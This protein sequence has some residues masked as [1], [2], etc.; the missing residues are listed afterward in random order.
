ME[1]NETSK[2]LPGYAYITKQILNINRFKDDSRDA[3]AYGGWCH[4][5]VRNREAIVKTGMDHAV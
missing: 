2:I 4:G 1:E 3:Y 5:C